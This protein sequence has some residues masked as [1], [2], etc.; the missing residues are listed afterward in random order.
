MVVREIV[1]CPICGYP[2]EDCQCIFSGSAHPDRHKREEV[3]F[4]HLYLFSEK[5]IEH[6]ICLES[7]WKMSYADEEKQKILKELKEEY[8][9][10]EEL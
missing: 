6:L 2:I 1:E 9:E 3:V 10:V 8:G 7:Y 5:Q 4:D